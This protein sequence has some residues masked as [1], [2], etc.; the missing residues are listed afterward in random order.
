MVI[1]LLKRHVPDYEQ[2]LQT[3]KDP[4]ELDNL[5]EVLDLSR[6]PVSPGNFRQESLPEISDEQ[7]K[8]RRRALV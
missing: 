5:G 8:Q 3:L 1:K 6:V 4:P 7:V 2:R